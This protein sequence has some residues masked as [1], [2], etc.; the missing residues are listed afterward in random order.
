[1][2]S[3][4]DYIYI[5]VI[6][7]AVISSIARKGKKKEEQQKTMPNNMP[8]LED[9]LTDTYAPFNETEVVNKEFADYN[10][11]QTVLSYDTVEDN[12]SVLRAK[13][14]VKSKKASVKENAEPILVAEDV[15]TMIDLSEI[16]EVKKAIIYSEVFN[17]KY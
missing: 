10:K 11:S 7:I 3:I 6:A 16:E 5:I 12:I 1:M 17:R 15:E 8:D 2:E 13:K 14:Q 9:V 4:G